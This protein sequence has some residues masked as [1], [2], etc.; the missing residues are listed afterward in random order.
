MTNRLSDDAIMREIGRL[1]HVLS[2]RTRK[3]DSGFASRDLALAFL[4]SNEEA[5]AEG[6]SGQPF[7]QTALADVM[8]MRPQT[9]GVMLADL[10]REGYLERA[11]S[12]S[13]RRAYLVK[14]TDKGRE[15][16][17]FVRSAWRED[18]ARTLSCLDQEEKD[19]F[20]NALVKLNAS[21]D[22]AD[23]RSGSVVQ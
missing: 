9:I 19:A 8:G 6:L 7:T 23:K 10:E 21:I 22:C 2:R 13:D 18:A 4:A 20:A 5:L 15:R 16:S 1:S 17:E 12:D 14:L 3:Q 11:V